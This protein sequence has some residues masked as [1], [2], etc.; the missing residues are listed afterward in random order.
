MFKDIDFNLDM[1]V[2]KDDTGGKWFFLPEDLFELEDYI[3]WLGVEGI[4]PVIRYGNNERVKTDIYGM[5]GLIDE[6]NNFTIH[7]FIIEFNDNLHDDYFNLTP[8]DIFPE[9]IEDNF[10]AIEAY[11]LA[12]N[13]PGFDGLDDF[14]IYDDTGLKSINTEDLDEIKY[15]ALKKAIVNYLE[16]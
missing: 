10:S 9:F 5:L 6:L 16:L 1:V 2:E 4:T 12:R 14:F 13:Y 11:S 7:D 3:N 8:M 15:Q